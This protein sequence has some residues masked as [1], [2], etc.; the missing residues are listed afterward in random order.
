MTAGEPFVTRVV[1]GLLGYPRGGDEVR[2]RVRP[3]PVP[4]PGFTAGTVPADPDAWDRNLGLDLVRITEGAALAASEWLG[5]RDTTIADHHAVK[6]MERHFA[7]GEIGGTIVVSAGAFGGRPAFRVGRRVGP[8]G[9]DDRWDIA[10]NPIDG[11]KAVARGKDNAIS[12]IGI[13]PRGTMRPLPSQG[14]MEKIVAGASSA[15]HLDIRA[16]V[17]DNIRRLAE[18]KGMRARDV[19][20]AVLDRPRHQDLLAE[21]REAGARVRLL[22]DGE[23]IGALMAIRRNTGVHMLV[24]TGQASSSTLVACAAKCLGAMFQCRP[25]LRDGHE[26]EDAEAFAALGIGP[27]DI[28][29]AD[30]LLHGDDVYFA[31][32]GITAG[33]LLEGV[34]FKPGGVVTTQSLLTRSRSGTTRIVTAE[35]RV[36]RVSAIRAEATAEVEPE[37]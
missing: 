5:D 7:Y 36:D 20:V 29:T 30:D 4:W 9:V 11:A 19:F 8:P 37:G 12:V 33:A 22:E 2:V 26:A 25:A 10:V 21:I 17:G 31:A 18:A 27:A 16:S 23:V 13:A 32:T 15:G 14:Y 28:L 24:S 34:Y 3:E 1:R 35:H 6:E